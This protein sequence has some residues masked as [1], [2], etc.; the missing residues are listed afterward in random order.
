KDGY[1]DNDADEN[2]IYLGLD[3]DRNNIRLRATFY[4]KGAYVNQ[5]VIVISPKGEIIPIE[6]T[7]TP[8]LV[9]AKD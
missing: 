8:Y 9:H 6:F 2:T 4:Y 1:Y 5:T 3:R 7:G